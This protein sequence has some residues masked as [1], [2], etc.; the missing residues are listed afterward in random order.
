MVELN[1]SQTDDIFLALADQT[2]RAIIN[3]LQNGNAKVTELAARFPISLN[4]V[5]K[6][7]KI[8]QRAGLIER[9]IKGREH[10]CSLNP[11]P[12][13]EVRQWVE[14][15]ENFWNRKLDSLE[16]SLAKRKSQSIE[17]KPVINLKR[18]KT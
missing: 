1:P 2:R 12:I 5:S 13:R 3:V 11:E 8:L 4:A 14:T 6:H 15:Y 7:L 17:M 16:I 10:W 18:R 9:E